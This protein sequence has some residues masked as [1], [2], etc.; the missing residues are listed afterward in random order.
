[1]DPLGLLLSLHMLR[2]SKLKQREDLV[3][4]VLDIIALVLAMAVPMAQAAE[5]LIILAL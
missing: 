1:M 5:L 3:M 4:G 2:L